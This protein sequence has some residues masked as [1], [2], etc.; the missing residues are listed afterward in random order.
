MPH[1][2]IT[3]CKPESSKV[4][5]S[6]Y[7]T[8]QCLVAPTTIKRVTLI[9]SN[10]SSPPNS[11]IENDTSSKTKSIPFSIKSLQ[12]LPTHDATYPPGVLLHLDFSF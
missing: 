3:K 4:K 6:E 9:M 1:M 5:K 12:S 2:Q 8:S 10:Q 7:K 11:S